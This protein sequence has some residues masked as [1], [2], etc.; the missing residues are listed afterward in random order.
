MKRKGFTLIE[1]LVVIAIIAMLMGILMP[2]LQ[3]VR[4]IAARLVCGSNCSA[5][6][7]A[8]MVYSNDNKDELPIW[9]KCTAVGADCNDYSKAPVTK[10]LFLLVRREY[11]SVDQFICKNEGSKATD[12]N[13]CYDRHPPGMTLITDYEDFGGIVGNPTTA[14]ADGV[15]RVDSRTSDLVRNA[16]THCSYSYHAPN[17][18]VDPVFL[19]STANGPEF[20]ILADK[21][22]YLKDQSLPSAKRKLSTTPL[23]AIMRKQNSFSHQE[24]GQNVLFSDGHVTFTTVP[25]VGI[26]KDNIYT[27]WS[28]TNFIVEND[29]QLAGK[30]PKLREAATVGSKPVDARDSLLLSE[31][32]QQ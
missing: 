2:A 19:P 3:K 22:P 20:A 13:T 28:S 16:G 27:Y 1:L 12:L 23:P 29:N 21:N 32:L 30:M 5:I 24:T 8:M 10:S 17:Q 26:D 9:G 11:V 15:V 31:E 25:T 7:K 14:K 6:G 4:V 18:G